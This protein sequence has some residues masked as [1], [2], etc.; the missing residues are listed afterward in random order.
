MKSQQE[1]MAAD[2]KQ[3]GHLKR[4]NAER[5]TF[6]DNELDNERVLVNTSIKYFKSKCRSFDISQ[7]QQDSL[8]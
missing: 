1:Q 2:E 3:R 7:Q 5:V 6:F 8:R 4:L